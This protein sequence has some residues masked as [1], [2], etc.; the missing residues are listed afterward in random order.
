MTSKAAAKI[1]MAMRARACVMGDTLIRAIQNGNAKLVVYSSVCGANRTKK[2]K[3]KCA[4]YD[5]PLF[6][7]EAEE[8]SCISNRA[9][10]SLGIT[11][12]NLASGIM[13]D[14]KG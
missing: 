9:A 10:M 12:Q 1:Q 2:L 11:D 5:V 4:Y 3:D 6:E 13:K 7:M 14:M 8:F